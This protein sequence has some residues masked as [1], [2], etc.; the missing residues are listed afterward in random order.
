MKQLQ[1]GTSRGEIT[2]PI[3]IAHTNWGAQTHQRAET[4]DMPL[5]CTAI[6]FSDGELEIAIIDLDIIWIMPELDRSIRQ[7]ITAQTGIQSQNIRLS[8]SHTHSGP[9]VDI[10]WA[11]EGDDLIPTYVASLPEISARAVHEAQ[12]TLQPVHIGTGRG[13]CDMNI[14]RRA[15]ADDG[16]VFVGRNWDGYV[17]QEVL[18]VSIDSLVGSPVATIVNYACHGTTMGPANRAITPDFPGPMRQTVERNIGGLCLFLQG[19]TGNVHPLHSYSADPAV[20]RHNGLRLG[21]EA[22]RIRAS[23]DPVPR[24]EYLLDIR[25]SGASFGTY[26]DRPVGNPDGTLGIVN[27]TLSLPVRDYPSV[28]SAQI[29]FDE[30]KSILREARTSGDEALIRASAWPARHAELALLHARLFGGGTVTVNIQG[31]RL[32]PTVLVGVPLEPFTETGTAIKKESPAP[33]TLFSGYTNGY[34][35]YIPTEDAFPLGGYEVDTSPYNENATHSL[36]AACL[37]V[38]DLLWP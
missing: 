24:E 38:I 9:I 20:Y 22:A 21:L 11:T 26:E 25:P 14:N 31:I 5:Y 23:I 34:Y 19:A 7:A 8:Y 1:A 29:D 28:S 36:I 13:L 33:Y 15:M 32:G 10:T 3:G 35:G 12:K 30:K 18:V 4:I 27:K 6:V 37:E 16:A 2:P 17:D